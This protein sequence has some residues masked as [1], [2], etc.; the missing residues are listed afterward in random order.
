M[1]PLRSCQASI[2]SRTRAAVHRVAVASGWHAL[3]YSY[4]RSCRCAPTGS[5][6]WSP[7]GD[8]GLEVV[9]ASQT[10]RITGV[11]YRRQDQQTF[12]DFRFRSEVNSRSRVYLP[13][14]GRID[15]RAQPDDP[16]TFDQRETL[17]RTLARCVGW[18]T[19]CS[20]ASRW[21]RPISFVL[22][23][24]SSCDERQVLRNTTAV[25]PGRR[26]SMDDR[27]R[28]VRAEGSLAGTRS[29]AAAAN[30]RAVNASVLAW[31]GMAR[32]LGTQP[33]SIRDRPPVVVK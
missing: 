14:E 19:Y 3:R 12:C 4:G 11:R 28:E 26:C 6:P 29:P 10:V 22:A 5:F 30:R 16:E 7:S 17:A 2:A 33:R 13:I 32:A 9:V 18:E 24:A 23:P 15:H 8:V 21:H 31:I 1:R 27:R 25:P 20:D